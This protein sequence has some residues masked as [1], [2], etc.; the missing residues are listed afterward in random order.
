MSEHV[1]WEDPKSSGTGG[2]P[3]SWAAVMDE[4]RERPGVWARIRTADT[5][6]KVASTKS[7]F[8]RSKW[9]DA[10]EWEFTVRTIAPGECAL[11]ARFVGKSIKAVS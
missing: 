9:L 10:A 7:S 6:G 4:V 11:Y 8:L 5:I 1:I 3:S 2:R